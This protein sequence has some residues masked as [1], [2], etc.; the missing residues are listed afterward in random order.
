MNRA[1]FCPGVMFT[2][3]ELES[4][5]FDHTSLFWHDLTDLVNPAIPDDHQRNQDPSAR[6]ETHDMSMLDPE[7]EQAPQPSARTPMSPNSADYSPSKSMKIKSAAFPNQTHPPASITHASK[8]K[9]LRPNASCTGT[10]Q[11][12]ASGRLST[13]TSASHKA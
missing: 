4:L 13:S 3:S 12:T 2:K 1:T 7:H 6:G 5:P 8:Q 9:R 10:R 11:R